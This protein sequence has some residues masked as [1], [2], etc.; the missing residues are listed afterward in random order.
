MATSPFFD[1]Y[2]LLFGL[3][4]V[5]PLSLLRGSGVW[6]FLILFSIH[7]PDFTFSACGRQWMEEGN[8]EKNSSSWLD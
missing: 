8:G 2:F 7:S 4:S 5:L 6:V 1:I 3:A